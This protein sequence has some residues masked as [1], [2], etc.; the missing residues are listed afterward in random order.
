MDGF[1]IVL[2][3]SNLCSVNHMLMSYL[4]CF[5]LLIIQKHLNNIRH[6]N[7]VKNVFL[8]KEKVINKNFIYSRI[9]KIIKNRYIY[10][11]QLRNKDNKVKQK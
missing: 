10:N 2:M 9:I 3:I 8:E 7:T 6:L 11:S 5:F 4:Q 1:K